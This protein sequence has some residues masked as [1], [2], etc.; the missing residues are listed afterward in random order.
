M[1]V[2]STDCTSGWSALVRRIADGENAAV[3]ELYAAL[4]PIRFFLRRK[5]GWEADDAYHECM[6]AV[7]VGIHG[8]ALR[9]P[10]RLPAYAMTIARRQIIRFI[11]GAVRVRQSDEIGYD[12]P[13]QSC[14]NPETRV[15]DEDRRELAKRVLG[16]LAP[17]S[18]EILMRFYVQEETREEIQASMGL[19]ETQ[20]RLQKSRA[21]RLFTERI[22]RRLECKPVGV[23]G[24]ASPDSAAGLLP[25]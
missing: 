3:A 13:D 12:F 8:G 9:E 22:R 7:L 15:I 6:V 19:S 10:E 23:S 14:C 25:A 4:A 24:Y 21:K 11:H 17:R 20:F 2:D 5:I 16:S 1:V 18:R